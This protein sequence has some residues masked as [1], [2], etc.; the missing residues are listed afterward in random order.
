M[1]QHR[2]VGSSLHI[3]GGVVGGANPIVGGAPPQQTPGNARIINFA[4]PLWVWFY[5]I[6][7]P[8]IRNA[9]WKNPVSEISLKYPVGVC[10]SLFSEGLGKGNKSKYGMY[11]QTV[12]EIHVFEEKPIGST[13]W[14]EKVALPFC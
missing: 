5:Q 1:W 9:T 3:V 13:P 10:Q 14:L 8:I 12:T 6:T 2:G 7:S 4:D 11:M